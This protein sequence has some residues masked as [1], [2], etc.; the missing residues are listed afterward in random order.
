MAEQT[1]PFTE[2]GLNA[3]FEALGDRAGLIADRLVAMGIKGKPGDDT[4]CALANYL[5][6]VI[7]GVA[8]ASVGDALVDLRRNWFEDGDPVVEYLEADTPDAAADF[9][10]VFD[11]RE[12]PDL[13]EEAA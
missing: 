1:Y 6:T 13:I 9:I 8:Y 10:Y 11:A 7:E 3:A 4:C 5:K 12:Y 2:E